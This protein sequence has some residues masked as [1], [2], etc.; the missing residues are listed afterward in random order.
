MLRR[1]EKE[2]RI[3]FAFAIPVMTGDRNISDGTVARDIATT[4]A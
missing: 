3:S 2:I 4:A 1:L